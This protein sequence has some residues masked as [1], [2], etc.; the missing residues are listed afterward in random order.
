MT[1]RPLNASA[2]PPCPRSGSRVTAGLHD[3]PAAGGLAAGTV[4]WRLAAEAPAAWPAAASGAATSTAAAT[5]ARA[6][7][8]RDLVGVCMACSFPGE[9][10]AVAPSQGGGR[11]CGVVAAGPG[12]LAGMREAAGLA[13]GCPPVNGCW[14]GRAGDFYTRAVRYAIL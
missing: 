2:S 5:A 6:A 3:L 12:G 10:R 8:E 13:A 9:A 1:V 4:A 11:C 7:R 14:W